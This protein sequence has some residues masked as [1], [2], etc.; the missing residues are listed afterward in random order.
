VGGDRQC[1]AGV[2]I[3]PGEDLRV[4]WQ[5]PTGNDQ[6]VVGEIGLQALVGLVGREADIRRTRPFLRLVDN[7]AGLCQLSADRGT[8]DLEAVVVL[9][10]PLMVSGP[11]SRPE[12]LS[13]ARSSRIRS[14]TEDAMAA[15]EVGGTQR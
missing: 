14:T 2:V 6:P 9:E 12:L 1:H 8:R 11:A 5:C 10:V 13:W 3:K 15:G 7:E 4:D